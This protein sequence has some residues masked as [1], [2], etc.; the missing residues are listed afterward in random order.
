[1]EDAADRAEMAEAKHGASPGLHA[2]VAGGHGVSAQ[3]GF[4]GGICMTTCMNEWETD[5][6]LLLILFFYDIFSSE[7]VFGKRKA[8]FDMRMFIFHEMDF[9]DFEKMKRF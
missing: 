5:P 9:N 4:D 2:A 6:G 1:M 7:I 3:S 8:F